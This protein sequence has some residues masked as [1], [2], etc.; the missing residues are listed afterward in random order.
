VSVELFGNGDA[1]VREALAVRF[2]V[3]VDEQHV[4][5]EIEIDEHDELDDRETVHAIVRRGEKAIAA[6]RF[7]RRDAE[8]AQIGR[9]AVLREARRSG[10]GRALLDGLLDEACRRGYRRA[11]LSAQTHAVAFYEKAGFDAFGGVYDDAGIPRRDME[12]EL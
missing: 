8:T 9:M 10:T 6:G 2:A 12:R 11:R 3:F 1:R 7:Y 5:P 4:P